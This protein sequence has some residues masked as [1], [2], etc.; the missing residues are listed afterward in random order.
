MKTLYID[1]FSGIAG[2]MMLGALLDLGVP[3]NYLTAELEKLNVSGWTLQVSRVLRQGISG[4]DV[5]VVVTAD[6]DHHHGRH[7]GEIKQV[8]DN[9]GIS[10]GA[11]AMSNAIFARL[12]QV[13]G[14]LHNKPP[15]D[16]HFHEV[17]SVDAIIDI[18]GTAIALD[19][20]R[21]ERFVCAPVPT[22]RGWVIC[23]HGKMPLPAPATMALLDG[24]QVVSVDSMGEWVTPTGAAIIAGSSATFGP[25]PSMKINGIGYGAGDANPSDRPNLL[26][27]IL[28]TTPER[29]EL[30]FDLLIEANVDDM[31]AE[32]FAYTTEQLLQAG[33]LDVW[34]TAIQMKK[35][36]PAHKLSVLCEPGQRQMM[37]D[38][39]LRE[40]TT[41]GLR[42]SPVER[43]KTAY[44]IETISTSLGD[45]RIKVARDGY[46]VL[47]RAP[48]YEDCKR[49]AQEKNLSLKEVIQ[50]VF[51]SIESNRNDG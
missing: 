8:I 31:T 14:A 41:I 18:C 10:N 11:K 37:I 5:K 2:D 20:L 19:W 26:R 29:D 33:A 23:E 45:I 46:R 49:I 22:P 12:A 36:R 40:S 51:H 13:E 35:G 4:L 34:S 28:G 21:V 30:S 27:L 15:E 6:D 44:S 43:Y 3:E 39:L 17:G 25:I 7:W 1:C 16:V 42:I 9:S 48:E 47:N 38:T 50:R 32:L 24:A